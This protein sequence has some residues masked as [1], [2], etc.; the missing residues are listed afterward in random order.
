MERIE[1]CVLDKKIHTASG[2]SRGWP[3]GQEHHEN[4]GSEQDGP[5]RSQTMG[6]HSVFPFSSGRGKK[7]E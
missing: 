7:C 5:G 4:Q 2:L 6:S 1:T 3:D